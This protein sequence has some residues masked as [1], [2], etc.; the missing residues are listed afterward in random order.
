M[1]GELTS[2]ELARKLRRRIVDVLRALRDEGLVRPHGR[3][4]R[5]GRPRRVAAPSTRTR[6]QTPP[7]LSAAELFWSRVV[8]ADGDGC[9][10]WGGS[11]DRWGYGRTRV[12]GRP[13]GAHRVSYELAIGPI[14]AGF[15]VCHRCDNPP[16]V[17]PDHLFAGTPLDN[18]RDR[19][20]KGRCRSGHHPHSHASLRPRW[21]AGKLSAEAVAQVLA[22]DAPAARLARQHN[23]HPMTILRLRRAACGDSSVS[24]SETARRVIGSAS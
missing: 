11:I 8:R 2:R 14:P 17:R 3:V 7:R 24:I 4:G 9:W 16:C 1:S 23:V 20:A 5:P 21:G 19:D 15:F 6:H 18:A 22:S 12:Q 13:N 10:L